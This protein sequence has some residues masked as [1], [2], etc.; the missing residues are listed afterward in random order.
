[1]NATN[2]GA[3]I[4]NNGKI[5]K[6]YSFDGSNDYM[7]L[8][9]PFVD[10]RRFTITLWIYPTR[11]NVSYDMIYSGTDN[12]ELQLFFDS[13]SKKLT[14]SINNIE[15]QTSFILNTNT[16]NKWYHITWCY[17][18]NKNEVYI[19]GVNILSNIVNTYFNITD[20]QVRIGSTLQGQYYL[21]A[22]INDIR[23]Y[24]KVL[25]EKEIKEIA[26]AK[27]LH[28]NFNDFQEPT[29]NLAPFTDYSNRAYN[30]TYSASSW[31]GDVGTVV[32]Y[33][34]GG[35][36][37]LPYKKLTKTVSGTGGSYLPD[38]YSINIENNKTYTISCYMKSS[39]PTTLNGYCLDLNRATDNAYRIYSPGFNLTTDW[40]RCM[41]IYNSG[42][43]DAGIYHTTGIIYNDTDLP[44]DIY[45]CEFQVEE[46]DHA[47]PYTL[48]SR[49]GKVNDSSG[50]NNHSTLSLATTP[51]Y[52]IGKLGSGGYWWIDSTKLIQTT[53]NKPTDTVTMN[54]W[55]K[56]NT[57]GSSGYHIPMNIDSSYYEMSISSSG[58]IR[59]GFN[60]SGTRYVYDY[61][62]GILD[63]NWHMLTSSYDGT[64][65]KGYIDGVEVGSTN[66]DEPS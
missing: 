2:S 35:Y 39:Y 50:Y 24:N 3:T 20:T 49:S 5:G 36:N 9:Q 44:I 58:K 21:G 30:N 60:L 6:C 54:C 11:I 62:S 64:Y 18:G 45:W 66:I 28:Y 47:T 52:T 61:G 55:F 46:K 40:V 53:L 10:G 31:G 13:I 19:N 43:S 57:S 34:N 4:D 1:L 12:K 25:S 56:S 14:T 17:D 63:G 51:K 33:Q 59:V 37:N 48:T 23:I 41:W 32:Y 8:N 26:R 16:I 65:I 22:K 27:I 29:V 15:T 38:H 7:I 42:S